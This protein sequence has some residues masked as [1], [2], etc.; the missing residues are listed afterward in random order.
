[1]GGLVGVLICALAA[2]AF[3]GTGHPVPFW[4]SVAAGVVAFW[5]WGVMHNHATKSA[6]RRHDW[7]LEVM[8]AEGRSDEEIARF[9]SQLVSPTELDFDAVPDWLTAVN[10]VATVVGLVL[11]VWGGFVRLS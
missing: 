1:V 11:L 2:L 6:N 10:Y 4:L 9:D 8:R 3:Y 7:A 5:S